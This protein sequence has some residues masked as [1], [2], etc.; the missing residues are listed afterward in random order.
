MPPVNSK[1]DAADRTFLAAWDAEIEAEEAEDR[2]L[3]KQAIAD[4]RGAIGKALKAGAPLS[5]KLLQAV[6]LT[7][8]G[9]KKLADDEFATARTRGMQQRKRALAVRKKR[10]KGSAAETK[11]ARANANRGGNSGGILFAFQADDITTKVTDTFTDANSTVVVTTPLTQDPISDAVNNVRFACNGFAPDG[12]FAGIEA[13]T[14]SFFTFK[15]PQAGR[16][17][18]HGHL[19]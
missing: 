15:L 5:A 19:T 8:A 13:R 18:V 6:G 4:Q 14:R 3:R 17:T 12:D 10:A 1:L 11:K 9:A 2:D 16:I 7:E